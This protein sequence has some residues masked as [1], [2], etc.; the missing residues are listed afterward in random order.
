MTK[1]IICIECPKGCALSV[2]V[3]NDKVVNVSGNR[4]PKGEPYALAEIEDPRRILTSTV[5]AKGLCLKMVPVRTDGPIPK[6]RIF[7]A[8][9]EIRKIGITKAVRVG[10]SL[11]ENFLGLE[12]NLIATRDAGEETSS[13]DK[14]VKAR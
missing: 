3:E 7:D 4:C 13:F 8:M 10:D 2:E 14:S 6:T 9:A 5:P 11:V 1:R 12:V